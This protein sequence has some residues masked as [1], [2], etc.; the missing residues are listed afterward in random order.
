[1]K[2]ICVGDVVARPG[3]DIIRERLKS[4]KEELN[5]DV[6]IVNGENSAG[7]SG[8][9]AKCFKEIRDAGADVI[10]LGDHTW[11]R[12]E[13][14][15]ILSDARSN[16]ICPGNY[17]VGDPPARGWYI[18][19]CL[20][21]SVGVLNVLGRTFLQNALDCPFR[22]AERVLS[23]HLAS[24]AVVVVDFHGEATSEKWAFARHFDGKV[25]LIYG[26]HTH[27]ATADECVL[28][29]GTA[30]I[31]DIGMTG[32]HSGVIGMDEQT[33]VNRFLT[34]LPSTYKAATEDVRLNGIVV[35]L[36]EMTGRARS[37]ERIV[38]KLS[39]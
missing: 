36:D 20:G 12:A 10:T 2:L 5:A 21:V 38:R 18:H 6:V 13:V 28:A 25:S 29:G 24:C 4:L 11:R 39:E 8:I 3:R 9:D 33:A 30:Y 26:T 23:E 16:C 22:Y 35:E 27:V 31:T 32:A 15:A 34:G 17:P 19:E 14:R 37:I 1:M 7:G